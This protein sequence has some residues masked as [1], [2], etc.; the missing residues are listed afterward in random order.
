[1]T[2]R[3][4]AF[5]FGEVSPG[6]LTFFLNCDPFAATLPFRNQNTHINS[7]TSHVCEHIEGL[8]SSGPRMDRRSF[9]KGAFATAAAAVF[10]PTSSGAERDWSGNKPVRYPDQDIVVLDKRFEKYKLGNTPIQ[11]LHTGTLWA[12]RPAWSAV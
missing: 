8:K 4:L 5:A 9:M 12:R 11:R 7:M 3:C 10:V 6:D 2:T 1:M